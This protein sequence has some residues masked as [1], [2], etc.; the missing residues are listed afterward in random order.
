MQIFLVLHI[1]Q[2]KYNYLLSSLNCF[3]VSATH[4]P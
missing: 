4:V 2:T 3:P 1:F